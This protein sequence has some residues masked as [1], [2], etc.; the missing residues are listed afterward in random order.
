MIFDWRGGIKAIELMWM[1]KGVLAFSVPCRPIW[2]QHFCVLQGGHLCKGED[3][4]VG[5]VVD[6]LL[7]N[8]QGIRS[9]VLLRGF[10]QNAD[11]MEL[12]SSTVTLRSG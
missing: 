7:V 10:R 12:S 3:D 8:C 1:G 6:K 5:E 2:R 4:L 9:S 11:H